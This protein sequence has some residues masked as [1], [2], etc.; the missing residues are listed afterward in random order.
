MQRVRQW[1]I[2]NEQRIAI[3]G[4]IFIVWV[5]PHMLINFSGNLVSSFGIDKWLGVLAILASFIV[6]VAVSV[7]CF[8]SFCACVRIS[9][10]EPLDR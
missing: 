1:V 8:F 6:T 2:A 9:I 3:V 7:I 4:G 5:L 10:K